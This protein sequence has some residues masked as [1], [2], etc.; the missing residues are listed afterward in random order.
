MLDN[1]IHNDVINKLWQVYGT[2]QEIP[3]PQRQGAIIILGMLALAKREVVTERV[4]TLL[5]IGLGPL[6]KVGTKSCSLTPD[7]PRAGPIHLHCSPAAQRERQKGQR[8]AQRQDNAP[9]YGQPG[10][11]QTAGHHRVVGALG[12][13]VGDG[14]PKLTIGLARPS[15]RSTPSISLASNP[16]LCAG[17][18]SRTLPARC[19]SL[20][21]R[22]P[23]RWRAPKRE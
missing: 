9:P 8:L 7:R 1:G 14:M 17:S 4:E 16:T 10:L 6:G 21:S 22:R 15:R 3:K 19:S 23:W 5:K 20:A 13:M 11:C 12:S 18:S 2:E